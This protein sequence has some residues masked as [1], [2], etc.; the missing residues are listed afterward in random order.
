MKAE[1]QKRLLKDIESAISEA[2]NEPAEVREG[3]SETHAE[4]V[5][6]SPTV[7]EKF[8]GDYEIVTDNNQDAKGLTL[9]IGVNLKP[10]TDQIK[11][12]VSTS[13]RSV[14]KFTTTRGTFFDVG[15]LGDRDGD[16]PFNGEEPPGDNEE[17]I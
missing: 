7:L 9:S 15:N 4:P 8:A 5:E 14:T 11:I 6:G 2:L 13:W 10:G 16:L 12:K 17:E 1:L 3:T